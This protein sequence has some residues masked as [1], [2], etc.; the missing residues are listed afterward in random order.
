MELSSDDQT[1]KEKYKS[2]TYLLGKD[3]LGFK[4]LTLGF[5]YRYICSKLDEPRRTRIRLWL[6]PRGHFKTTLCTITQSI[7]LQ[8]NTPSIRIAIVSGVLPNAKSMVTAIGIPY[9][10]NKRFRTFFPEYCPIKP[11]APETKW[12]ESQIE[13]PNR[14]GRPV[15]ESTFEA[16]GADST[17]TS[18]HY[19]HLIIDDLVTRE[20]SM[21]RDQ[22][23]KTKDFYKALFPLRDSPNT[24]IDIVGTRWDDYDLYGELEDDPDIEVIKV[25]AINAKG[26]SAFPERYSL[27]ELMNIKMGAKMG[28]YLFSCLYMLNPI[29][30]EDAI[31]KP[32]YFSKYFRINPDRTEL[33]RDDGVV[34]PVGNCY[35][36]IDGA[37]E[38]GKN[39]YSAITVGFLSHDD[40]LYIVE[41]FHKQVD[42]VDFLDKME[43]LY[44]KWECIK[45]AGQKSMVEK[46]LMSF[47]RKKLRDGKRYMSFEP[48]GKNTGQNKEFLIKQL[49]PWYEGGWVWHNENMRGG[50]L[51]EELLRFPKARH[52]DL[53]DSTQMLLEIIRPSGKKAVKESYD[54]NS[55]HMWK[56]RLKRAFKGNDANPGGILAQHNS[57]IDV[58]VY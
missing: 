3:L 2:S 5:H 42:P 21:T 12:T 30:S 22:L 24:P 33:T 28:S 19:D 45:F 1:L 4:D 13:V 50:A 27:E 48:L 39:D 49:Q 31:F 25:P 9:L 53:A 38:E 29:P 20:N 14:G 26:E 58:G 36:A 35:M 32:N 34:V 57:V 6:L 55:I 40:Y 15:M 47:L 54:R 37:T 41:T 52:D 17:L 8:L 51:E 7:S 46:M 10:S 56:R 11:L 16:F 43:E 18:R 44:N 23:D